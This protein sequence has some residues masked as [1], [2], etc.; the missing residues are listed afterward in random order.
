MGIKKNR[1]SL[2]EFLLMIGFILFSIIVLYPFWQTMVLSF[3]DPHQVSGLGMNLWPE[4]WIPDAYQFVFGYG[5]IMKAYLNTVLRTVSGTFLIV[6]FTMS[7]G[8]SAVKKR[9]AIPQHNHNFLLN[10]YVFLR[11]NHPGLFT[12]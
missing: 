4:R 12:S 10:C 11:G 3:S 8:L 2:F 9:F 5:S 1:F 6:M 7:G